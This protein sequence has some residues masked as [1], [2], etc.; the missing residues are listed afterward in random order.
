MPILKVEIF[1]G[2]WMPAKR[3]IV[4]LGAA[5]H[6]AADPRLHQILPV[7]WPAKSQP[8]LAPGQRTL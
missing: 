4:D 7:L 2:R 5:V 8:P 6:P 3:R 1:A